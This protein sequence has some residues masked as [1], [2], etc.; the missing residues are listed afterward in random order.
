M[1]PRDNIF[2][3]YN[4]I[5]KRL[6]FQ[7]KRSAKGKGVTDTQYRYSQEGYTFMVERIEQNE[8]KKI[9]YGY[10]M[11]N[12]ARDDLALKKYYPDNR[13]LSIYQG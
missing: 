5:G 9:A 12:G 13:G 6:P 10:C 3:I 1:Y 7:V 8:D 4:K 2:N 11:V